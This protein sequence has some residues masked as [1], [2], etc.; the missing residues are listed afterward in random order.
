MPAS[1]TTHTKPL[2][3]TV[4]EDILNLTEVF[5]LL[6]LLLGFKEQERELLQDAEGNASSP[7]TLHGTANNLHVMKHTRLRI[8]SASIFSLRC[9]SLAEFRCTTAQAGK[10]LFALNHV[11]NAIT[12]SRNAYM[13]DC[14]VFLTLFERHF[15]RASLSTN[16]HLVAC[17]VVYE[18]DMM[19]SLLME[20]GIE[21][22]VSKQCSIDYYRMHANFMYWE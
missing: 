15:P 13:A 6:T 9:W 4:C 16:A 8:S 5:G 1:V 20:L 21:K 18:M 3:C 2:S 22:T 19:G 7:D 17:Q 14:T 12:E 10:V 11:N